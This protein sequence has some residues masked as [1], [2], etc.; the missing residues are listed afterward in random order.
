MQKIHLQKL[1]NSRLNFHSQAQ[2]EHIHQNAAVVIARCASAA[3]DTADAQP[4]VLVNTACF[5]PVAGR[6]RTGVFRD[7]ASDLPARYRND[8]GQMCKICFGELYN[9]A[10]DPFM[11]L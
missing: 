1:N 4:I 8:E 2:L 7:R 9:I 10:I 6:C 11:T 5:P 3:L